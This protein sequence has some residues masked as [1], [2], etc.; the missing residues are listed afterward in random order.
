MANQSSAIE[1][2]KKNNIKRL[3]NGLLSGLSERQREVIIN[4]FGLEDGERKTLEEIGKGYRITRERVRQIENDAKAAILKSR[5]MAELEP[6][7]Q[8][9]AAHL[10]KFGGFRA[11]YKLFSEDIKDLMPSGWNTK[12]AAANLHFLLSISDLFT[13]HPETDKLHSVWLLRGADIKSAHEALEKLVNKLEKSLQPA[14]K[15]NILEW[16]KESLVGIEN[17]ALESILHLS[18]II[19]TNVYGEYGLRHWPEINVRGVRDKA[20]LILKKH[21][22]PMHFKEIVSKINETFKGN[23]RAHPQTVHNELIKN[24]Q[25][26]LVGRGT[27]ALADWGYKPG[28][29]SD[30]L[31]RIIKDADRPLSREEIMEA[32]LK[33][34]A[35]KQNTVM[36]NLQNKNY[37]Q[38]TEEGKYIYKS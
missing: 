25:F 34:R 7:F 21:A 28:T 13:K 26:V 35:V 31:A 14:K 27:Y 37:F 24:N 6:F 18:K 22:Q 23:R 12:I 20:F 33:E 36:L 10:R 2:V 4:R 30:V 16:L 9:L 15:E 29:V 32:V 17:H 19:N 1:S 8:S 38:K 5:Y 3:I 11:E